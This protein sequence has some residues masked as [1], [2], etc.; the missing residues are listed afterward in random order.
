MKFLKVA[1]GLFIGLLFC[2]EAKAYQ[3]STGTATVS[4][5]SAD[6]ACIAAPGS[7]KTL[8]IT[9]VTVWVSTAAVG[10][11]GELALEDGVGGTRFFEM[12]AD[13][14][15]TQYIHFGD[16]GY[17]LTENTLLNVTVDGAITTQ[18]TGGCV[19]RANVIR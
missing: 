16:P 2:G 5:G 1:F 10:G 17:P 6:A 15:G 3:Q 14:V 4:N 18:A 8:Y 7:G 12:D 19:A 13:A 9:D 11:G